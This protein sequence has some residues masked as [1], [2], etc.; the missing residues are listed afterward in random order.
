M[1]VNILIITH[2]EIGT[3]L[4]NA[5]H[6]TLGSLP[7][8]VTLFPINYDTTLEKLTAK[9]TQIVQHLEQKQEEILILTDLYGSTPF[10]IAN[11]LHY[12]YKTKIVAGLNLPMLIRIMN[13]P[14]LSLAELAQKALSGGKEGIISC[15]GKI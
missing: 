10:N 2:E 7:L 8:S 6:K 4:L 9:L 15:E 12:H 5:V 3:A 11:N 14:N 1:T 13:Y